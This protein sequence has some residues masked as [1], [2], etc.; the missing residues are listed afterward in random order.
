M[1][2]IPLAFLAL[3]VVLYFMFDRERYRGKRDKHGV[4]PTDEVFRDPGTGKLMRVHENPETGEREYRPE[5]PSG[6]N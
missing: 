3:I 5:E 4:R 2:I 1:F 6:D